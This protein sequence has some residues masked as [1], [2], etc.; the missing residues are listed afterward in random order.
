MPKLQNPPQGGEKYLCLTLFLTMML[1]VV[2]AV[3][4]IYSIVIVYVP[5]KTVLESNLQGPKMCTTLSMGKDIEGVENCEGW[6]SCVEW[7]LSKSN[8]ECSHVYAA[9]RNLGTQIYW[10][11]CD[12][13]EEHFVNHKCNTLEDLKELNCKL[14]STEK[15]E[16]GKTGVGHAEECVKFDN[17]QVQCTSG[18]CKNISEVYKCTFKDRLTDIQEDWSENAQKNWGDDEGRGFCHCRACTDDSVTYPGECPDLNSNCIKSMSKW[19]FNKDGYQNETEKEICQ[20]KPCATCKM[21]CNQRG[22]CFDMKGRRDPTVI[23]TDEF[24]NPVTGY[25]TC[26]N[27]F[28]IEIYDL[29]CERRCDSRQFDM[30]EKNSVIFSGENITIAKCSARSTAEESRLNSENPDRNTLFVSCSNVTIDKEANSIITT[31]CVNGTWFPNNFNGGKTNYSYMSLEYGRLREQPE[32]RAKEVSYEQDITIYP[33]TKLKINI[34]GCVNTLSEECKDFY[35]KYGRDGRNYTAR[36]I[37]ECWYDPN[38]EDF[39]VINFDP[40]KTLMLLIFFAAIPGGILAFSCTYMCGC[41]R[42]IF[43]G[44]DGHMR[45]KCCGNYVTGIGNV[46]VWDPPRRKKFRPLSAEQT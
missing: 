8:K 40:D 17:V 42:F 1:A 39:V 41:S 3:A 14:F 15:D 19:K 4:M 16:T 25:Y 35:E 43:V 32:F 26:K 29:K 10:D 24:G 44:E 18:V 6:T 45:L 34:E 38:N 11:K 21:I 12:L 37:Y 23:G 9:T 27:G 7:C 33:K 13:T 31:D 28:C 2:S 30:N 46:P 22:E 20:E 36:A 5:A